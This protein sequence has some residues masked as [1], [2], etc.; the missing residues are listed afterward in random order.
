MMMII[1]MI[2]ADFIPALASGADLSM[3]EC[4]PSAKLR[5]SE[6]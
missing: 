2:I 6:V 4:I 1:I 3:I 5:E